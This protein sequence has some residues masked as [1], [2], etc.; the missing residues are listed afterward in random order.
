MLIKIN[1]FSIISYYYKII[2]FLIFNLNIVYRK[3]FFNNKK[4]KS[5]FEVFKLTVSLSFIAR[6]EAVFRS[7]YGYNNY[8]QL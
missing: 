1:N 6:K 7:V 8:N 4:L 3:Q 5:L 2:I